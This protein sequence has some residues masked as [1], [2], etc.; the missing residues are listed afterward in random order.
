MKESIKKR[1]QD[2]SIVD[3]IIK[4]DQEWRKL[5]FVVDNL[6][7]EYGQANKVVAQKK[8]ESKG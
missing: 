8:K 3:E 6:K 5:R 7:K 1:F 4:D 2:P